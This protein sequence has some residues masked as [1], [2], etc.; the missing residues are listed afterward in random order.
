MLV[1]CGRHLVWYVCPILPCDFLDYIGGCA[2][3]CVVCRFEGKESASSKES[4]LSFH[5]ATL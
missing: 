3:R 5:A 4:L 1:K 2:T